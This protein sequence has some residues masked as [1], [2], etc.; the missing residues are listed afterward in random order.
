MARSWI[1]PPYTG[2]GATDPSCSTPIRK[3]RPRSG[4]SGL[5]GGAPRP[6]RTWQDEHAV[7]LNSPPKPSLASV[8][9]GAV[10]HGAVKNESPISNVR[11]SCVLRFGAA[12]PN[13]FRLFRGVVVSPP[14][15]SAR[16]WDGAEEHPAATT[17][18]AISAIARIRRMFPPQAIVTPMT[19]APAVMAS[20]WASSASMVLRI[21]IRPGSLSGTP[22]TSH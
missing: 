10:T 11:R 20:D 6:S 19:S 5:D 9:A 13:A 17:P 3:S 2:C 22:A 7:A 8:E 21:D 16:S 14:G 15:S 12:E 1:W 18:V 4:S